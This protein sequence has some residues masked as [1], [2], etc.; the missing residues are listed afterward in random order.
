[1]MMRE[2]PAIAFVRSRGAVCQQALKDLPEMKSPVNGAA[3]HDALGDRDEA[4][5]AKTAPQTCRFNDCL[6]TIISVVDDN[7]NCGFGSMLSYPV[8]VG[9]SSDFSGGGRPR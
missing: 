5:R 4:D 7:Y 6:A 8:W 2:R 1:M 9:E 3:L